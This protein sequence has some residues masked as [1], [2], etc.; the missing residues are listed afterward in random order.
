MARIRPADGKARSPCKQSGQFPGEMLLGMQVER[1]R[2]LSAACTCQQNS[3]L[4]SLPHIEPNAGKRLFLDRNYRQECSEL[5][6]GS[7][8][9]VR[10]A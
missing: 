6:F 9:Y 10:R 8:A 1:W 4:I 3:S 2:G 5:G 7:N